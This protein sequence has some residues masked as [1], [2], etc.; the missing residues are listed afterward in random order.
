MI[1]AGSMLIETL[2]S[3][4]KGD[5]SSVANSAPKYALADTL[6]PA[7]EDVSIAIIALVEAG[8]VTAIAA[9]VH[10]VI[11]FSVMVHHD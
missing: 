9:F 4:S 6:R 1:L 8:E 3:T 11:C 5:W 2:H 7:R 10:E